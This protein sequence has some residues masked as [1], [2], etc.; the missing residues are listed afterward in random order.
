M[1]INNITLTKK[2]LVN[3]KDRQYLNIIILTICI[4]HI[5]VH[6]LW[7]KNAMNSFTVIKSYNIN[8]Q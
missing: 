6:S 2:E 3:I 7:K 8:N 5:I 4:I 1:Y